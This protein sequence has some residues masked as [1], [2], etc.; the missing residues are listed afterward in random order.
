MVTATWKGGGTRQL[1]GL[2]RFADAG[3]SKG[4]SRHRGD[5]MKAE[6]SKRERIKDNIAFIQN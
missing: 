5:C 2:D 1:Q 3:R 4:I 6:K